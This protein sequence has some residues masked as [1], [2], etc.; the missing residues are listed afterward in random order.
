MG[1]LELAMLEVRQPMSWLDVSDDLSVVES[2][3]AWLADLAKPEF[4]GRG[5]LLRAFETATR[6][7]TGFVAGDDES[8]GFVAGTEVMTG[9]GRMVGELRYSRFSPSVGHHIGVVALDRRI[10]CSG[11]RLAVEGR[12]IDTVASPFIVPKSWTTPIL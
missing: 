11:L 7:A 2:R 9:D 3:I 8:E 5:A 4:L 1:V 12:V 10:C 6:A